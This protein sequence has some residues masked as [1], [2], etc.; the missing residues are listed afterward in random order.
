MVSSM[1]IFLANTHIRMYYFLGAV[2]LVAALLYNIFQVV[3]INDIPLGKYTSLRLERSKKNKD[4]SVNKKY[5]LFIEVFIITFFQVLLNDT[6]GNSF[7]DVAGTN[8]NYFG[9]A[10]FNPIIISVICVLFGLDLF[11]WFE[12]I[13]PAYALALFFNKLGCFCAGCCRGIEFSAGLYNHKTQL[14]EFPVQLVEAGVALLIF[15]LLNIIR[16]KSKEGTLYPIYLILYSSTRFFSEFLRV[17]ED[18]FW[19]LKKYHFLCLLG[20]VVGLAEL[21]IIK[22]YKEK[23]VKINNCACYVIIDFL[24]AVLYGIGIKKQKKNLHPKKNKTK[25]DEYVPLQNEFEFDFSYL[26]K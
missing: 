16:K 19:I 22:K 25:K 6:L 5:F 10:F 14:T 24:N 4:V 1:Y 3:I 20:I 2:S 13:T 18:V 9:I 7:G 8:I 21:F 12:L 23:I 11:K 15:V 17:E 26:R